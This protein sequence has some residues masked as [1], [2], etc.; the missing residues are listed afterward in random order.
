MSAITTTEQVWAP[1]IKAQVVAME[2][3][4]GE[5]GVSVTDEMRAQITSVLEQQTDDHGSIF[6]SAKRGRKAG[7]KNT[8]ADEVCRCAALTIKDGAPV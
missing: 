5:H 1:L 4:L 2:E 8:V 6:K 7:G 3:F